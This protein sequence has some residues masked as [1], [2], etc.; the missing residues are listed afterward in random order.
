MK[1]VLGSS[2]ATVALTQKL[3]FEIRVDDTALFFLDLKSLPQ[4]PDVVSV[5]VNPSVGLDVVQQA[6]RQCVPVIWLQPGAESADIL[7]YAASNG[8][9]VV[10]HACLMTEHYRR[11]GSR[12]R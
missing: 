8:F 11:W 7:A 6:H 10:H 1:S 2:L 12:V 3:R 4:R 5:V 9:N